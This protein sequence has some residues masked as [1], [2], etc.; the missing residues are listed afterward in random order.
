MISSDASS[1][2]PTTSGGGLIDTAPGRRVA[3]VEITLA[4]HRRFG[5]Q[6]DVLRRVKGLQL[7][8][9]RGSRFHES[10]AFVESARSELGEKCRMAI[11]AER[12]AVAETIT[13]Q[14]FAGDDDNGRGGH[15]RRCN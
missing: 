10:H 5:D 6:I 4:S 13:R 2:A 12:M 8:A 1:V 7:V 14:T 11:R 9:R 3:G 15:G